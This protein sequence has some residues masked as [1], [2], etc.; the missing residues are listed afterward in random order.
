LIAEEAPSLCTRLTEYLIALFSSPNWRVRKELLLTM[1][2]V[3]KHMGQ[4]YF[5]DHFLS[6]FVLL[7]K[8]KVDEVREACAYTA[9]KMFSLGNIPIQWVCDKILPSIKAMASGDF[10]TR[11]SM[12]TALRGFLD[13][14]MLPEKY[15]QDMVALIV[16][17]A[18]D[19]VPNIRLRV[20]QVLSAASSRPHLDALKG[21]ILAGLAELQADKDRDVKY[22]A[23]SPRV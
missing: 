22:F 2:F 23:S 20:A 14:E 8:D 16:S 1:P 17:C 6:P 4:D 5:S 9:P 13:L 11:T 10:L 18:K 15:Q 3:A 7:L 19:K 12:V 21:P